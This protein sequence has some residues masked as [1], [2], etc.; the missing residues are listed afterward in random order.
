MIIL[1]PLGDK[2]PCNIP[3]DILTDTDVASQF[4]KD[5]G[6]QIYRYDHRIRETWVKVDEEAAMV[7]PLA[8][9][10][11][12]YSYLTIGMIHVVFN[13]V[14]QYFFNGTFENMCGILTLKTTEKSNPG[15]LA[16]TIANMEKG[17]YLFY[18]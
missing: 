2:F 5:Y 14:D 11:G 8:N 4:L 9:W 10:N 12:N 18:K 6:L 16:M 17:K 3:D 15:V 13:L 1:E 7:I